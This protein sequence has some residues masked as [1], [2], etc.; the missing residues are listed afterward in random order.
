MILYTDSGDKPTNDPINRHELLKR[1]IK[2][3]QTMLSERNNNG[4]TPFSKATK[5][6]KKMI[7]SI[8]KEAEQTIQ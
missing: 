6:D 7:A 5:L 3:N 2:E 4:E 1:I 8:F